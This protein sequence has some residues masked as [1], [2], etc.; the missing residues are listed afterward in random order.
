MRTLL[1]RFLQAVWVGIAV[2][3]AGRILDARWHLTHD[4]F[5]ATSQQFE[6][7]WLLWLGVAITLVASG[8]A[9]ARLSR[10]ER[11]SGFAVLFASCV[12]YS[13][14]AIWH[15]IEHANHNDPDVAHVLLAIGQI[16]MIAGAIVTTVQ[17][18]RTGPAA[19]RA[20]PS[21]E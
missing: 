18:R 19:L 12:F 6:A 10:A 15:F 20:S 17:A 4:E 9:L 2:Q 11:N 21:P 8:L 14:I 16:A 3:I 7:H 5:E 13:G 1:T